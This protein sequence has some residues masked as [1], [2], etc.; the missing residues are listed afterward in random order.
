LRK[1]PN[2]QAMVSTRVGSRTANCLTVT[3][4]TLTLVFHEAF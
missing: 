3:Q 4:W 1:A 2:M